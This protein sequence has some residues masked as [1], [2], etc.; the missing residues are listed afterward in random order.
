MRWVFA[1]FMGVVKVIV[2]EG[3]KVLSEGTKLDKVQTEII[4]LLGQEC[5]NYYGLNR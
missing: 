5:E 4:H 2:K 3:G 1:L